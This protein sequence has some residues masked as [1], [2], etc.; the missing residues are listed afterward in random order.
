[1][2]GGIH[3]FKIYSIS[4]TVFHKNVQKFTGLGKQ[5]CVDKL[6]PLKDKNADVSV[7]LVC[8]PESPETNIISHEQNFNNF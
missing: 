1:M 8:F 5:V 3:S 7:L 4:G 6:R 2:Y